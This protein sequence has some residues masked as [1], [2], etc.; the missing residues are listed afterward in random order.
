[1]CRI[2]VVN[3]NENIVDFLSQ[4]LKNLSSNVDYVKN[5]GAAWQYIKANK[6]DL[7]ILGVVIKEDNGIDFCKKLRMSEDIFQPF[8]VFLSAV[9]D[10]TVEI[11]AFAAGADDYINYPINN[12]LFERKLGI[13]IRRINQ[14]KLRFTA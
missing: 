6:I 10:D 14:N 1:M 8:L 11:S 9:I 13:L 4:N 5:I 3:D 12:D 2:L 7:V